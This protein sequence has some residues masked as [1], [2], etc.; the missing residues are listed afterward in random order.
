M[1]TKHTNKLTYA[2]ILKKWLSDFTNYVNGD[3]GTDYEIVEDD[4]HF[5]YQVV[6]TSWNDDIFEFNVIFYFQIKPTGKVWLL[7]NNTDVLVADDL[8]EMGIPKSDI[9]IGFLPESVRPYSGFAV[10]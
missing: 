3:K 8:V 7:V 10:A 2:A 1:D 9:V 5:R 4:I 6:S